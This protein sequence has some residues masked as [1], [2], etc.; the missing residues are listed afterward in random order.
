MECCIL[1][2][3]GS[4]SVRK[5]NIAETI[6]TKTEQQINRRKIITIIQTKTVET[7]KEELKVTHELIKA[8]HKY[9]K[10]SIDV[11]VKKSQSFIVK[12]IIEY[13]FS[14]YQKTVN[15]KEYVK[16]ISKVISTISV[17]YKETWMDEINKDEHGIHVFTD[18]SKVVQTIKMKW[19]K[20]ILSDKI[21]SQDMEWIKINVLTI[22]KSNI[23]TLRMS[24][25]IL[26][27]KYFTL[28]EHLDI[29]TFNQAIENEYIIMNTKV[30][31]G[32][33]FIKSYGCYCKQYNQKHYVTIKETIETTTTCVASG[34]LEFLLGDISYTDKYDDGT[35]VKVDRQDYKYFNQL[36]FRNKYYMTGRS[37][38]LNKLYSKVLNLV[39]DESTTYELGFYGVQISEISRS[40]DIRQKIFDMMELELHMSY[41][42]LEYGVNQ[43]I[44]SYFNIG[45]DDKIN[46]D[47]Y[48]Y[49]QKSYRLMIYENEFMIRPDDSKHEVI[50]HQM[51]L[52]LMYPFRQ[53]VVHFNTNQVAISESLSKETLSSIQLSL[54]NIL[55]RNTNYFVYISQV[56]DVLR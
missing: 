37:G 35:I 15:E 10:N 39:L 43:Q 52:A 22:M 12:V 55:A 33:L 32:R 40:E 27:I 53:K 18:I 50:K 2:I 5:Y 13:Y 31:D 54:C 34:A 8:V 29:L 6:K 3:V 14:I 56:E 42:N 26:N 41:T 44:I 4:Q 46:V 9:I 36:V 51:K 28:I 23:Y 1:Q 49:S 7:Y 20:I 19:I 16:F 48:F 17:N 24:Q 25:I 11:V 47:S 21:S 45:K 38:L 30:S